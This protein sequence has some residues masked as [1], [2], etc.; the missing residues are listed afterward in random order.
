MN[1][2]LLRI[3]VIFIA[4]S[5]CVNADELQTQQ[6]MPVSDTSS[7]SATAMEAPQDQGAT[8]ST[9]IEPHFTYQDALQPL[10]P[11][12]IPQETIIPEAPEDAPV[13]MISKKKPSKKKLISFDFENEELTKI[14][15]KFAALHHT[16]IIL[17]TGSQAI[18]QK[19]TFKLKK[20][21]TLEEAERYLDT[22]LDIAGYSKVPHGDFYMI[23]KND[24]Q[25]V[26]EPLSLF[27]DVNPKDL[28][29]TGRIQVVYYLKNI[30]VPE[31]AQAIEPLNAILNHTLS[32]NR[33]YSFDTKSNAL[34]ISDKATNI[35]ATMTMI[36]ELDDIGVRDIMKPLQLF[37]TSAT[38]VAN[39]LQ[40][41]IIAVSGT[42][43]GKIRAEVKSESGLYFAPGT[44]I[45]ADPR[46]NSIIVV[47]KE[48][49]VERVIEFVREYI[50]VPLESGKSILHYYELQ[51][52]DSE[53]FAEV[54][55]KIIASQPGPQ[56]GQATT[57]P[58]GTSSR[59]FEG[60]IV[61]AEKL[62]E[63]VIEKTKLAETKS[64]FLGGSTLKG[65]V[66]RGGNRLIIAAKNRDWVRIEKLIHDLDKPQLQIIVQV[67]IV[68][69][70]VNATK[71][72]GMQ[73]RNPSM[74]N[75]PKGVNFQT[76][77]LYV[78]PIPTSAPGAPYATTTLATDLLNLISASPAGSAAAALTNSTTGQ[79]GSL[80]LSFND[81]N[82]SGI[83]TFLQWLENFGETRIISHPHLVAIN[84]YKAEV[85]VS[86]IKRVPG[87]ASTGEGGLLSQKIE[88]VPAPLKVAVVPR[89]SSTDRV[90][91]QISISINNFTGGINNSNSI[92][93]R[94]LHTDVNMGSG[95]MLV[96]GGL[97]Q[98]QDSDT[99]LETPL[100]GRI[101]ILRWLFGYTSTSNI[102]TN[103]TVFVIPTVVEPKIRAGMNK[104]TRDNINLAYKN[105]EDETLF[106]QMRDPVTYL[107]FNDKNFDA[108][109]VEEYLAEASEDF[110]RRDQMKKQRG[111]LACDKK[112]ITPDSQKL[113]QALATKSNPILR[114]GKVR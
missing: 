107:F 21:I 27:V 110:V 65:T 8:P 2:N 84:N 1:K 3:C 66:Y 95:E 105:I 108:Q 74:F 63:E 53:K 31:N 48:P 109:M 23:V 4:I 70:T 62:I 104:F 100:L 40:T 56:S 75:L 33:S 46:T 39:I 12:N 88:D 37:N 112:V 89:A 9:S 34:I 49:A 90:N 55:K 111:P 87:D 61:V 98:T 67:M 26:R 22:L 17:P 102:R 13:A 43:Q 45:V 30:K 16:N 60:V 113:K 28:P 99:D 51:Y 19:V 96:I 11:K 5:S 18:N 35:K 41:Q 86:Q 81:P 57:E 29:D 73:T 114:A 78:P 92:T 42:Q 50:D 64:K 101:P 77:N 25:I 76:T 15:N 83:W 91:L 103:V 72:L 14:I 58:V 47:G 97:S 7:D 68:D 85:V 36:L 93:T 32:P 94:E 20:K 71:I 52:L 54:L 10:E 24:P 44:R 69:F 38:T 59:Q 6:P 106:E 82:G 80:I 79:P